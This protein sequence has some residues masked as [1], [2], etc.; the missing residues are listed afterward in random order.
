MVRAPQPARTSWQEHVTK[1]VALIF[2]LGGLPLFTFI[3]LRAPEL[4]L[5]HAAAFLTAGIV[6]LA[7]LLG[8]RWQRLAGTLIW[9][10]TVFSLTGIGTIGPRFG[11]MMSGIL[12][13]GLCAALFGWRSGTA[14]MI[15]LTSGMAMLG[16]ADLHGWISA[17]SAAL[18]G[19]SRMDTWVRYTVS[20]GIIAAILVAILSTVVDSLKKHQEDQAQLIADLEQKNADQERFMRALSHDLKNPLVTIKSFLGMLRH[21]MDNAQE[22][23]REEV[24]SRITLAADKMSSLL[25]AL[26]ELASIGGAPFVKAPVPM[27]AVLSRALEPFQARIQSGH[28]TLRID[29]M[30][31]A[32]ID[33]ERIREVW[34]HL[35]DNALKYM[36]GQAHPSLHFGCR[37]E[38]GAGIFF[39]EDNG[40]GID[41]R[42]REKVFEQFDKL[43]PKSEGAGIGLSISR[44]IVERHGGSIW[45]ETGPSGRG[46]VFCFSIPDAGGPRKG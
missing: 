16:Y 7:L 31:A 12:A 23:Q 37:E 46:S 8:L 20:F 11:V 28:V 35:I 43:D 30:P 34:F 32:L 45:T 41:P 38:K 21:D 19:E 9:S 25:D 18:P 10:L 22:G 1:R 13:S 6:G 4:G 40:I 44:R 39:I 17:A 2:V 29:R 26:L 3:S 5:V 36:G 27:E 24:F 33:G 14:L 15:S 42:F